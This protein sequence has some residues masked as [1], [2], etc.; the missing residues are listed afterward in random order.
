MPV[1]DWT[2]IWEDLST[3]YIYRVQES[4]KNDYTDMFEEPVYSDNQ[5]GIENGKITVTNTYNKTF[6]DVR[7]VW[8]DAEPANSSL[9]GWIE[10]SLYRVS[11]TYPNGEFVKKQSLDTSDSSN[12]LSFS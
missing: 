5:E 9:H 12:V 3:D 8:K 2:V 1:E 6:I 7:K 4:I 10:F 11:E